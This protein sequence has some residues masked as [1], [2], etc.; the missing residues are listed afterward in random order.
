MMYGVPDGIHDVTGGLNVGLARV[1][2]E[3]AQAA[4]IGR[5]EGIGR[6]GHGKVGKKG[7]AADLKIGGEQFGMDDGA[8]AEVDKR[9]CTDVAVD[10]VEVDVGLTFQ[11]NAKAMVVDDEGRFLLNDKLEYTAVAMQHA[12]FAG[13]PDVLTYRFKVGHEDVAHP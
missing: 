2:A 8:W 6:K 4:I 7:H 12:Q 13:E 5:W 11:H 1:Q 3:I 9:S 10:K